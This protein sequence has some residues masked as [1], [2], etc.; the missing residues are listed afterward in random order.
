MVTFETGSLARSKAGHDKD[1]LFIIIHSEKEYVYLADGKTRTVDRPKCK[2]KKH[3]QW[4]HYFPEEVQRK[5]AIGESLQNEDIK[6]AIRLYRRLK[7]VKS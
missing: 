3:V 2:K 7:N 5:L 1:N 4:I 6:R